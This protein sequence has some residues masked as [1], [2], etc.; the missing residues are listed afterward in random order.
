MTSL[1]ATFTICRQIYAHTK[2]KSRSRRRYQTIIDSLVQSSALYCIVVLM[3]AALG[4]VETLLLLKNL[5]KN[6]GTNVS[7]LA[8]AAEYTLTF[9]NN[10]SILV[11][12]MAPT[13]M[14]ARL[15]ASSS[16]EDTEMSSF[17]FPPD[18]ITHAASHSG[19]A[20]V[21]TQRNES[22]RIGERETG[23]RCLHGFTNQYA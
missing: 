6:C 14:V 20:E 16:H 13:L 5:P 19:G 18:V 9:L 15:A 22:I 4:L 1:V 11:A 10:L 17:S 21:E 12:G 7:Q 23:I 2:P 3:Q 8:P